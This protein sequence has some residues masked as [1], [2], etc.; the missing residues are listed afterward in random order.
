ML[1][2][3]VLKRWAKVAKCEDPKIPESMREHLAYDTELTAADM[4]KWMLRECD[5][6]DRK[7]WMPHRIVPGP[8]VR[9]Y[10]VWVGPSPAPEY[11]IV[12]AIG[13]GKAEIHKWTGNKLEIIPAKVEKT[14]T[15]YHPTPEE[16]L[17]IANYMTAYTRDSAM[18]V[19]GAAVKKIE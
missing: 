1:R 15:G 16:S 11:I 9:A 7:W 8:I 18:T 19:D 6:V 3:R 2:S 13:G 12:L 5:V 4:R 14:P 17:E 10:Y